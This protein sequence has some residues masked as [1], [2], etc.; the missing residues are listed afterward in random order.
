M[1][2]PLVNLQLSYIP[3]YNTENILDQKSYIYIRLCHISLK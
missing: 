3:E 2:G 1:E